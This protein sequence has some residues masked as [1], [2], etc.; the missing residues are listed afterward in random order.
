MNMQNLKL[1]QNIGNLVEKAA[2]EFGDKTILTVDHEN[3]TISFRELNDRPAIL[4]V[5]ASWI[6][7]TIL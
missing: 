6:L 4:N 5:D 7:W 1:E 3:L 2:K